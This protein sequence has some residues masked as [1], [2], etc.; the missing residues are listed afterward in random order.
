MDR[1]GVDMAVIMA[2]GGDNETL[3]KILEKHPD[4]FIG[5]TMPSETVS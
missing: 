5:R 3:I 1:Y 2:L 4:R